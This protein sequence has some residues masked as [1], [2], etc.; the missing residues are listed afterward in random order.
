ILLFKFIN[1]LAAFQYLINKILIN[2]L[3][4]FIIVY[5][6]NILIFNKNK[7]KYKFYIY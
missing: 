5:I 3:D 7:I 6:N 2:F 1:R 4:K